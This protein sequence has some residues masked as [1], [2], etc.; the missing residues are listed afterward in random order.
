M[1]N[2]EQ[3][4]LIMRTFLIAIIDCQVILGSLS[5][6][7][8]PP[9]LNDRQLLYDETKWEMQVGLIKE[10]AYTYHIKGDT[11]I[12]GNIWKKVYNYTFW[13]G[14]AQTYYAA[15]RDVGNKVYAIRKGNFKPRLLYD[16]SLREGDIV[17]C[18]LESTSFGCLLETDEPLD[19]LLGFPFKAFLRV[20]RIDTIQAQGIKHRFFTLTLLDAFK[21]PQVFYED[22]II[23]NVVWVEGVGSGSGPFSPW[24]PLHPQGSFFLSCYINGNC[25]FTDQD[26]YEANSLNNNHQH[27]FSNDKIIFDLLGRTVSQPTRGVYIQGKK[28]RMVK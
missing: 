19:T 20:E 17:Q 3:T 1:C 4:T 25:I 11:L 21:C 8:Q 7:A 6:H 9:R 2:L 5:V 13:P 16:F 14:L 10:N 24:L 28:K 22:A 12:N 26:F 18:G 27:G 15:I 23:G